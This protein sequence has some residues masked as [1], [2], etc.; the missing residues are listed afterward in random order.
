LGLVANQQR[1]LILPWVRTAQLASHVLA[2]CAHQLPGDFSQRYGWR[3]VLLETLVQEPYRGTCYRAAQWIYLGPTR[4]RGKLGPHPVA[5]KSPVPVKQ[6]WVY[7]L[8][9]HFRRLLCSEEP[10]R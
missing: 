3:P 9:R 10:G 2:R 4:G 6:L 1:F 5:G 7:P 8:V